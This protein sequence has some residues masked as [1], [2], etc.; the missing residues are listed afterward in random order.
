MCVR[1]MFTENHVQ[2]TTANTSTSSSA[3][4][5]WS[6]QRTTTS[7][8]KKIWL[9]YDDVLDPHPVWQGPRIYIGVLEAENGKPGVY[10]NSKILRKIRPVDQR[11][12]QFATRKQADDWVR[13]ELSR[14]MWSARKKK[15]N[16]T[17]KKKT[18]HTQVTI[19][20]ATPIPVALSVKIVDLTESP[21]Q[22]ADNNKPSSSPPAPRRTPTKN[23]RA[24]TKKIRTRIHTQPTRSAPPAAAAPPPPYPQC[25]RYNMPAA[26][27]L[28]PN[29]LLK[30]FNGIHNN[31]KR[32]L[33]SHTC[34]TGAVDINIRLRI[35]DGYAGE[36]SENEYDISEY[37]TPYAPLPPRKTNKMPSTRT[38]ARTLSYSYESSEEECVI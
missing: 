19:P 1:C 16:T 11:W 29:S 8:Q 13:T 2:A 5:P 25:G 14:M 18:V 17:H 28:G 22:A 31:R 33:H 15:P 37:V 35:D 6:V 34:Y 4:P 38:T 12:K 10:Y 20:V 36:S 32:P 30:I 3:P 26:N 7:K 21:P 27:D 23:A 24:R 9:D